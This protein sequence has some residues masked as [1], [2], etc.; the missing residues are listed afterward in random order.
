MAAEKTQSS[1]FLGGLI[2]LWLSD[3]QN[4]LDGFFRAAISGSSNRAEPTIE[5]CRELEIR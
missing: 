2:Q 3:K 5:K 4:S 1:Y